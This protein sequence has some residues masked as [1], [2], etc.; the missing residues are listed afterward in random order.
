MRAADERV[1]GAAVPAARADPDARTAP[2][3]PP[4]GWPAALRRVLEDP[5]QP[6]LVFQPVVDVARG[7]VAGYE[8]LSRFDDLPSVGPERWFAAAHAHGCGVALEV[9][10][11]R[12]ALADHRAPVGAGRFL[13]V[14]LSPSLL[15]EPAVEALLREAGDLTGVVLEL[16]E[17][18]P[19]GDLDELSALLAPWR[20]AGA[21]I[22]LDDAGSGYAGLQQLAVLRPDVVKLDL[23][24]VAGIDRDP[25]KLALA[26]LL[27]SF[28]GRL[29]AW[30]LAEGVERREELDVLAGLGVPLAQ[31]YLLGTPEPGMVELSVELAGHLLGFAD[32]RGGLDRVSSLVETVSTAPD[33]AAAV[34]VLREPPGS[35]VVVV[36]VAGVP[37]QLVVH[38]AEGVHVRPVSLRV[39]RTEATADVVAR[40]VT[41]AY[42][43]RLDPLVCVDER[44]LLLGVVHLERA[45]LA[46]ADRRTPTSRRVP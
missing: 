15:A 3:V 17:H 25:V 29:D 21:S 45:C 13:T 1:T 26:E 8:A 12:R 41:R 46:L 42:G 37:Q 7:V 9:R 31:G 34:R 28:A 5:S 19:F 10:V 6:R 35:T 39:L 32:S 38:G 33:E 24:L 22:A 40:A 43:D 16:T 30:L 14:N 11:L 4:D 2:R 20:A 23:S 36:D 27:G 44:G 18:V